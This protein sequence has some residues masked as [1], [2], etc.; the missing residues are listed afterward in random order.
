MTSLLVTNDFPPKLGGIQTYLHELWC[1]LPP[2][3]TTVLTTAYDGA[4]AWDAAQPF[5]VERVRQRVLLPTAA[6]VRRV[7][8]LARE[9][10]ADV[11]FVDPALPLGWI[12]P[13]LRAA[14]VVIVLHGAE[15]TLPGRL[16]PIRPLLARVLNAAA[17]VVSAGHYPAR[18]AERAAGRGLRGIV[19]PPGVDASRFRPA[20]DPSERTGLRQ[21]FGLDPDAPTVVGLSRLVPRKGFDVLVDAVARLDGVTLALA[22][23]GRDRERLERRAARAGLGGRVRFLG[24]VSE[25]DLPTVYRAADVF[26]MLCRD[27]WFGLEAEGFGIVFLEAAATGVPVVAGRSGG[28]H[29]AVV[30]GETGC[31]VESRDVAGVA[32]A[33][34]GLL[35]DPVRRAEMG[36]AARA[37]AEGEWSYATRAAPLRRLASGDLTVLGPLGAG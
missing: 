13:R 3:E 18:E 26:A 9:V 31:V 14:P 2:D 36:R 4:A 28:S 15:V 11:I 5:R 25:A 17:G 29:E 21:G 37:R 24:R 8:A 10:C 27:R 6:V 32:A 23:A 12:G 33:L 30:A 16:W 35:R 19:V 7:D 1:R 20:V 22:G 34:D